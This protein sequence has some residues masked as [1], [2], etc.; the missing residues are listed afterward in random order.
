[1]EKSLAG[2]F[3][4]NLKSNSQLSSVGMCVDQVVPEKARDSNIAS[5]SRN[6][7]MIVSG[8]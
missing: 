7:H 2:V 8:E 6:N 1:M 3:D 4:L 5:L